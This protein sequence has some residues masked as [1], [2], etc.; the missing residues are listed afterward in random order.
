[1]KFKKLFGLQKL[2]GRLSAPSWSLR[3]GSGRGLR[4]EGAKPAGASYWAFQTTCRALA[5]PFRR[6]AWGFEPQ[7]RPEAIPRLFS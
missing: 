3:R 1:M 6:S 4:A 5:A 7:A 2:P